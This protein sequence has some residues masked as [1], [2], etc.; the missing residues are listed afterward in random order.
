MVA[1]FIERAASNYPQ[2]KLHRERARCNKPNREHRAFCPVPF[3]KIFAVLSSN[4]GNS[5]CQFLLQGITTASEGERLTVDRVYTFPVEF[6]NT[7]QKREKVM[8]K[9]QRTKVIMGDTQ[10]VLQERAVTL[11]TGCPMDLYRPLV[12]I[13]PSRGETLR[14]ALQNILN[15][16]E[17]LNTGLSLRESLDLLHLLKVLIMFCKIN[18]WCYG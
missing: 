8:G 13:G 9:P 12:P 14:L 6:G 17:K 16:L 11:L 1:H 2:N 18:C 3:G 7:T 15:F 10:G 5:E 4:T